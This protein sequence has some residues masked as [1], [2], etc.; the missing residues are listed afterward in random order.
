MRISSYQDNL[1]KYPLLNPYNKTKLNS[2]VIEFCY[3]EVTKDKHS[4]LPVYKTLMLLTGQKPKI[5]KAKDSVAAFKIRKNLEIGAL[6]TVGRHSA[7]IN[8]LKLL[9]LNLPKFKINFY[10]VCLK[11]FDL[12]FPLDHR[13]GANIFLNFSNKGHLNKSAVITSESSKNLT[14]KNFYLSSLHI[15]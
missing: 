10:N 14:S 2:V 5:I 4:L 12:F 3:N 7:K 13:T 8:L 6:V 1:L 15:F 9:V 11:S